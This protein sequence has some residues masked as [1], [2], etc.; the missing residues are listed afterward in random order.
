MRA[1]AGLVAAA[2]SDDGGVHVADGLGELA[3]GVAFVA[4]QSLPTLARAAREELEAD[5]AFVA[6]GGASVS[7]LGVPSGAKIACSR[8]PQ[9][10]RDARRTIRNRRRHP[11]QSA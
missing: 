8:K 10:Y 3:P 1:G 9:K 4:E 7:A 11:E 5:L 2:G 6:L